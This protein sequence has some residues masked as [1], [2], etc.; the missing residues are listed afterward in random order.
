MTSIKEKSHWPFSIFSEVEEAS[1]PN[2]PR[3]SARKS[4]G[5][6]TRT[7]DFPLASEFIMQAEALKLGFS[8]E[9]PLSVVL[10]AMVDLLVL[11]KEI[12]ANPRGL[13]N[14][15]VQE[16]YQPKILPFVTYDGKTEDPMSIERVTIETINKDGSV[17]KRK[18]TRTLTG[19]PLWNEVDPRG[20]VVF[21][22]ATK[23]E[24]IPNPEELI[25]WFQLL[26]EQFL[27]VKSGAATPT[28][29]L[30]TKDKSAQKSNSTRETHDVYWFHRRQR[31]RRKREGY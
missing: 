19:D 11:A 14:T 23:R 27:R 2:Q 16:S 20:N 21:K 1:I 4:V 30:A 15:P 24:S 13:L 7:G 17:S 26:T 18:Q 6:K 31:E 25:S 9:T 29:F 8:S 10:E 12:C 28:P 5:P 3:N 22:L